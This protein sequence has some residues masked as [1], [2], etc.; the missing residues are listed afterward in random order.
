MNSV[1]SGFSNGLRRVS[2]GPLLELKPMFAFH[3]SALSVLLPLA[4][5]VAVVVF[6]NRTELAPSADGQAGSARHDQAVA[7]NLPSR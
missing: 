2:F 5:L 3:R 4:L 7:A 6:N 1:L